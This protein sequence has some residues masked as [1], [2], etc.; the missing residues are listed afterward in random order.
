MIS[1]KVSHPSSCVCVYVCVIGDLQINLKGP[2]SFSKNLA[3]PWSLVPNPLTLDYGEGAAIG[4]GCACT[5]VLL[6]STVF[7]FCFFPKSFILAENL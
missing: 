6:N 2:S 3:G 7:L 5:F 4:L 1:S